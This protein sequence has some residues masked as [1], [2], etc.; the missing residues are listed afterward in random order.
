MG[1][2]RSARRSVLVRHAVSQSL[3]ALLFLLASFSAPADAATIV[4]P[5]ANAGTEAGAN[6]TAPFNQAF[7]YQQVYLASE[8]GTGAVSITDLAF[9]PD[10]IQTNPFTANLANVVVRLSTTS[11]TPQAFPIAFDDNI[12][13]D[14]LEVFSGPLGFSS[15]PSGSPAGFDLVIPFAA[16][17]DYDPAAGNL[18]VEI[19]NTSA[20]SVSPSPEI[21]FLD[22]YFQAVVDPAARV[23]RAF[24]FSP[25]ATQAAAAGVGGLVTQ[26][27]V[28]PEP[29]TALLL[30]L[31][32][33]VFGCRRRP[34][35]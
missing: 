4:A 31:G 7:R 2:Q 20:W 11:I 19:L 18:L 30:G 3:A 24:A 17:F 14:E 27:S 8:F 34:V 26:F 12:G 15:A 25:T 1:P 22:L 28:V 5:N 6:S 10:V 9:R 21:G 35:S 29:T 32:L 23:G 16:P 33:A 13:A